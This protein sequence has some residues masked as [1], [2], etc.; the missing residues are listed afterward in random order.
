MR[1]VRRGITTLVGLTA[2]A[3]VVL[4]GGSAMLLDRRADVELPQ[5]KAATNPL[6]ILE[7][8]R[9]ARIEGCL[10]CHGGDARGRLA[11]DQ[12]A[13]AR[14]T[15]PALARVA[16]NA[17]D[18]QLARAIRNGVSIEARPL[19]MMPTQALN[20]LS[21]EDLA[22]LIGW[23]RSLQTSA[24]DKVAPKEVGPLGRFGL[25]IGKFQDSVTRTGGQPRRRPADI[26]RYLVETVCLECHLIDREK[27]EPATGHAAPPLAA[28][29]AGYDP[30]A[31]RTLLRTG[32]AVGNRDVGLMSEASR[33]GLYALTDPEIDSIQAY[34]RTQ[35]RR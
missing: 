12:P 15:A 4:Y 28:M 14:I 20:R 13:I 22:R 32:K 35:L 23:M 3:L 6:D 1:W 18:G 16:E 8:G 19:F 29:V 2:L 27:I 30:A 24:F 9:L 34:L 21:D 10:D 11:F 17:T 25:L 5:I 7:G 31:L 33:K 26:G